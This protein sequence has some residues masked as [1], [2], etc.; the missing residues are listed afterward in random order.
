MVEDKRSR[1]R[2][3]LE[4]VKRQGRSECVS[5]RHRHEMHIGEAFVCRHCLAA[6]HRGDRSIDPPALLLP[7]EQH[8]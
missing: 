3:M 1:V 2:V 5:I 4:A 8:A 6:P 7:P